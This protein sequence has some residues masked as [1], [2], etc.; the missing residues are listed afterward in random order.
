MEKYL[1]GT[2]DGNDKFGE[3]WTLQNMKGGWVYGWVETRERGVKVINSIYLKGIGTRITLEYD[4]LHYCAIAI[5]RKR[6]TTTTLLPS[7]ECVLLLWRYCY[8][9]IAIF[10]K[11]ST[12][13]AIL[14][15]RSTATALLPSL[16][17]VLLLL[18]YCYLKN[19]FYCYC[20]TAK[21]SFISTATAL[22]PTSNSALLVLRYCLLHNAF[23][24]YCAT[25]NLTICS[26]AAVTAL[27][28][29]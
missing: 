1:S 13:T 23:Y 25:A 14:R 16:E 5:F 27:M 10:R 9:A 15:M 29:Q 12:A 26:T 4:P 6:F 2:Y 22:L 17:N 8:C 18:R 7:L 28:L 19:A 11:C 21:L 3:Q 24:C 20:P